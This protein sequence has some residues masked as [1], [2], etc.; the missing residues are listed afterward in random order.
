MK[1]WLANIVEFD[2]DLKMTGAE[3]SVVECPQLGRRVIFVP[4]QKDSKILD[5]KLIQLAEPFYIDEGETLTTV[6]IENYEKVDKTKVV[7]EIP[8]KYKEVEVIKTKE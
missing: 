3:D 6:T 2:P 1:R 5:F 8:E 7:T 4:P